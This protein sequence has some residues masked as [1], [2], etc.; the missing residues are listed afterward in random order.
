MWKTRIAIG[1]MVLGLLA[2]GVFAFIASIEPDP[3]AGN[4]AISIV[5]VTDKA[6]VSYGVLF[7]S[8]KYL[9]FT[10]A[11]DGA[12]HVF[13]DTDDPHFGKNN[14][15]DFYAVIER[16]KCYR[17]TSVGVRDPALSAYPNI[18]ELEPAECWP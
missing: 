5:K 1:V 13:E 6:R 17:I 2:A 8:H 10:V 9:I 11:E 7:Q 14:S 16:G 12:A 18:I 3:P 4:R 15:S